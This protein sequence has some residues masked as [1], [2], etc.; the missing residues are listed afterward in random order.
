MLLASLKGSSGI[1]RFLEYD[2]LDG[3]YC[4]GHFFKDSGRNV[5]WALG[6]VWF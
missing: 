1:Y 4:R 6:F 5:I 3:C 2:C